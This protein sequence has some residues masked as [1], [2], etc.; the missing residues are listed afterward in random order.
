MKQKLLASLFYILPHHLISWL[1]FK[2]ARIRWSP[3]KNLI[4]R[5]YTNLNPVKMHE[6]TEQDMFAN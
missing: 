4:I 3:V 5:T 6:A 1:M 2:A